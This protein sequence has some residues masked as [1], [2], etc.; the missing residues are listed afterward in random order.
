MRHSLIAVLITIL[1]TSA[2]AS[3]AIEEEKK[4]STIISF[5]ITDQVKPGMREV[6]VETTK[7]WIA[8]MKSEGITMNFNCFRD[9]HG[10][11]EY[12]SRE[13][14]LEEIG[15][16]L[17]LWNQAKALMEASEWGR[18]RKEAIVSSKFTIWHT[19]LELSYYRLTSPELPPGQATFFEYFSF[20]VSPANESDFIIALEGIKGLC[21]K[22]GIGRPYTVFRNLVGDAGPF[23]TVVFP[24]R[25]P[26]D[27]QN[28]KERLKQT[29]GKEFDSLVQ[30]MLSSSEEVTA[31]QGWTESD[32]SMQPN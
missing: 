20:R 11:F 10:N 19:D 1:F 9:M 13:Y 7:R 26:G 23:F 24:A 3:K 27:S 12:G 15:E 5:W 16:L 22:N 8:E 17:E 31:S 18:R 29:L 4:V 28:F 32:L 14:K 30:A 6:Y 21:E 2:W 25:D